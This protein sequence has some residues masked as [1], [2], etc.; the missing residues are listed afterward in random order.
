MILL[1]PRLHAVLL[2]LLALCIPLAA[3]C[4]GL[5]CPR[6]DPTGERLFIWPKDQ[7]VAATPAVTTNPV[8]PPVYTDPVFPAQ[9]A[10][11]PVAQAPPEQVLKIT[12]ERLLAPIGSEVV[13]KAGICDSDGYLV[14]DQKLEWILGRNGVGQ[15]VEI[16]GKGLMHQA[17][18]P[19]KK[20]KKVDNYLAVGYTATAPLCITRGT[21]DPNDDV[22]IRR[23]D[24]WA[25]V[26]S[27]VEGTSYVT[28]H[29]PGVVSWNERRSQAT[30][31][32]VDVQ[33]VFPP[34]QV[35]GNG[36]P[37]TLTTTVTRQS[38]GT[39]IEGY[40]V[41][42]EVADGAALSGA[43]TGQMVEVRTGADGRASVEVSPTD[44]GAGS[45]RIEVRLVRPANYAG[46]SSPR[47]VINDS[48]TIVNWGGTTP[49]LEPDAGPPLTETPLPDR[50]PVTP[51]PTPT[52]APSPALPELN[53]RLAQVSTTPTEAG[54]AARFRVR[55]ANAG[56][57]PA[58]N[59]ALSVRFDAGL[60]HLRDVRRD[61]EIENPNIGRIDPGQTWEGFLT[62]DL[63][64]AGRQCIVATAASQ[65][66]TS[67]PEEICVE[68]S[69]PRPQAV[70]RVQIEK[71]G[72]A[73]AT[74]REVELFRVRVQN[75]GE[76]ALTNVEIVDEYPAA[77]LRPQS[78]GGGA[79]AQIVDNKVVWRLERLEPQQS[80]T[81]EVEA[82]AVQATRIGPS[83]TTATVSA[84]HAE[85]GELLRSSNEHSLEIRPA[86]GGA[87][88]GDA[89]AAAGPLRVN[90]QPIGASGPLRKQTRTR[91]RITVTNRGQQTDNNVELRVVFPPE[92]APDPAT[93]Q[94]PPGVQFEKTG[95]ALQFTA[96]NGF[97]P[98]EEATYWIDAT[99][100]AAGTGRVVVQARSANQTKVLQAFED[101]EVIDRP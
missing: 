74:A 62:F 81:F 5:R 99:A 83:T 94:G 58:S 8:A 50:S 4:A 57:S 55:V 89:A 31:H 54:G 100:V 51:A 87:P 59:V 1:P 75:T 80:R 101:V 24:G 22:E 17:L 16:G 32:W 43:Q 78:T 76:V 23:G 73:M 6:I 96:L 72:P 3:G 61:L 71:L 49:Y 63:L 34:S 45:S 65:E 56:P 86:L 36:R 35:A 52:P 85:T 20:G 77:F 33:W 90:I 47:L 39:P 7:P 11:A 15:F 10:A 93:I 46:T 64:R 30:I 25:S 88:P 9:A 21:A 29:A 41:R 19:W 68:V 2:T 92:L 98:T 70:A 12:P 67:A 42:Y 91:Y 26:T 38:D 84:N 44:S 66:T 13:L 69:Q 48:T 82:L 27:A 18:L 28:A 53:V 79:P 40:V 95:N 14:A 60:S 37:Q 97:R